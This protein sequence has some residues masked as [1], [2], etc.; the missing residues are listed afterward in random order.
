VAAGENYYDALIQN[1]PT[2]ILTSPD[3]KIWSSQK[4]DLTGN[5]KGTTG[6]LS[7]VTWVNGLFMAA[8]S[9]STITQPNH[10]DQGIVA[11]S[12]DGS[13]WRLRN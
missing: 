11:T 2:D 12:P 4:I 3:G 9:V 8:D 13:T 1:P 7:S 6:Y 10:P 5:Q